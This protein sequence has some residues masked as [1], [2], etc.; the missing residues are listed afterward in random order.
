[1]E[2]RII[3]ISYYLPEKILSNL[4]LAN[5]YNQ[6]D[7]EKSYNKLGI[8][9][10]HIAGDNETAVDLAEKAAL[11][12]FEKNHY[13]REEID[14]I[15]LCTQ[16]PDYK[17]PTSACLLQEKLGLSTKCGAFDYNL[18]CSGFVY[19]LAIAKGFIKANVAKNILLIM[20][21]T[22]SKYIHPLDRSTRVLFGDGAAA[23]WVGESSNSNSS[24]NEFVFGTDGKGA[25]NLIVQTGGSRFKQSN[26]KNDYFSDINHENNLYMDGLEIFNFTLKCIPSII[27]ETLLKNRITL[28]EVDYFIFHQAN[29][30]IL[31]HLRKKIM[32]PEEKFYIDLKDTGN[33]VSATI[34]IGLY[35]TINT[36][37]IKRG[38]KVLLVGF[39]VGYSLGS[40]LITL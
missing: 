35:N 12:L 6:W 38:D 20:S 22:Y 19:G 28:D 9:I 32:I 39:G 25:N 27:E 31:E 8:N 5:I 26:I 1:M 11:K 37:K 21:E 40:C 16:S 34:P 13:L 15:I 36:N 23:I 4:D 33:T 17:L 7:P 24:I 29:K 18:G 30:Y 2:A 14:F 3:D 10:R